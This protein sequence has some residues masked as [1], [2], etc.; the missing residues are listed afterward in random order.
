MLMLQYFGMGGFTKEIEAMTLKVL[1]RLDPR[2]KLKPYYVTTYVSSQ[3]W[4]YT[5]TTPAWLHHYSDHDLTTNL[6]SKIPS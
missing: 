5:S 3:S 1:C 6:Q 4:V 2:P